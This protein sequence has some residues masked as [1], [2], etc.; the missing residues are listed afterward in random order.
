VSRERKRQL[1]HSDSGAVVAHAQQAD[2]ALLDLDRDVPRPGVERILDQL[3][4][5]GSRTL[6]DLAGSDLVD[7]RVREDSDRHGVWGR[8]ASLAARIATISFR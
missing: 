6:D 4:G 3:L 5:D 7:E 2:A 8:Q 1:A